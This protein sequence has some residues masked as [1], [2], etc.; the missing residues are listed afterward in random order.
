MRSS[1]HPRPRLL[2]QIESLNGDES[3]V[4]DYHSPVKAR[5]PRLHHPPRCARSSVPA[6]KQALTRAAQCLSLDPG[7]ATTSRPGKKS[8][9]FVSGGAAGKLLLNSKGWMGSKDH[10]LHQGEGCISTV[11]WCGSLIAWANELGVKL[12]DTSAHARI[13]FLER[14]PDAPKADAFPPQ[15]S[16]EDEQTL[17]IGWAD[18]VMVARIVRSPGARSQLLPPLTLPTERHPARAQHLP[19]V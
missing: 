6:P 17:I 5:R 8:R 19:R 15:L 18:C 7:Y 11:R 13:A 9:Q 16:W 2:P 12:Y 10:T 1:T 3:V 14:P 4:C